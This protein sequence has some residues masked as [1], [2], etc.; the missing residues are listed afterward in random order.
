MAPTFSGVHHVTLTVTDPAPTATEP[1]PT[2][3]EMYAAEPPADSADGD[4][5]PADSATAEWRGTHDAAA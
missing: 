2:G 3:A 5:P 4:A 1:E